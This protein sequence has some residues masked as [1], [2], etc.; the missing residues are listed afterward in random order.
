MNHYGSL[1]MLA[2]KP[3]KQIPKGS[4]KSGPFYMQLIFIRRDE[5]ISIHIK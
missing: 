3:N 4:E 2:K 1:L 5:H